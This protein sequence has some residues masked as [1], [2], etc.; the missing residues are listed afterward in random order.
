[1][2]LAMHRYYYTYCISMEYMDNAV[3]NEPA[4]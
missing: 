2:K 1:M 3:G 4:S